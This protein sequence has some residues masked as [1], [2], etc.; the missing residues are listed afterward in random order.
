MPPSISLSW[1]Y[2]ALT[3]LTLAAT[4]ISACRAIRF[5]DPETEACGPPDAGPSTGGTTGGA[6]DPPTDEGGAVGGAG[7][8]RDC[9]EPSDCTSGICDE[10]CQPPSCDDSI[11][12]GSESDVDCGGDC[13]DVC[14]V[15]GSCHSHNDCGTGSCMQGVC[16]VTLQIFYKNETANQSMF[17]RPLLL[18]LNNGPTEVTLPQLE[19]RY[20][21]TNDGAQNEVVDCHF[22]Q[23][24]CDKLLTSVAAVTPAHPLADHYLSVKFGEDA[25]SVPVNGAYRF[26]LALHEP[27]L[28]DYDQVGDYSYDASKSAYSLHE[29]V[30]LYRNGTLIW[31]TE[32]SP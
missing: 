1:T 25:G 10:T 13:P 4:A 3:V 28:A 17:I 18:L 31:G 2:V 20:F 30:C 26:E 7:G 5:C 11:V 9:L 8:G 15:G 14:R 23:P 16:T 19:L 6:A 32:P 12:N 27:A 21:Y 29:K 22:A 24:G